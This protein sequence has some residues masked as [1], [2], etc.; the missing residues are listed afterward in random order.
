MDDSYFPT[1]ES[2]Q[3]NL[4]KRW[5]KLKSKSAVLWRVLPWLASDFICKYSTGFGNY[6]VW[7]GLHVRP[8]WPRAPSFPCGSYS[9][10]PLLTTCRCCPSCTYRHVVSF[11]L[12]LL[13]WFF[14]F[15]ISELILFLYFGEDPSHG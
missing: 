15:L 11:C 4:V 8:R 7:D 6:G 13:M 2:F 5:R 14:F 10:C 1:L 3:S 9:R 12:V